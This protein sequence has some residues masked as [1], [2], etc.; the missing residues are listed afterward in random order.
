M[1]ILRLAAL[2]AALA[3]AAA[4]TNSTDTERA[5]GGLIVGAS[6][7]EILDENPLI[8]AGIG[9]GAGAVADN[10]GIVNRR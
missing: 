1:R 8:G 3:A 9:A 2:P 5:V 4:C 10:V 7:A 6:V